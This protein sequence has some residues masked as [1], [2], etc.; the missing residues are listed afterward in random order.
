MLLLLLNISRFRGFRRPVAR[1]VLI[2]VVLDEQVGLAGGAHGATGVL[3]Q[4][5]LRVGLEKWKTRIAKISDHN[6]QQQRKGER[7]TRERNPKAVSRA[8]N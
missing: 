4:S 3:A 7:K 8:G 2:L 5:G 6:Q 1:G